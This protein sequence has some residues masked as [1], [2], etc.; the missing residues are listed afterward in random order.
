M[1][2]IPL[3]T[4]TPCDPS[5]FNGSRSALIAVNVVV[6]LLADAGMRQSAAASFAI[7]PAELFQVRIFGGRRTGRSSARGSGGL[8]LLTYMFLHGDILHLLSN[9][10]FLWVFGDNV[11]DAM[12]HLKFLV[13]YLAVRCCRRACARLDAADLARCR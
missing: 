8:T 12:G 4:T 6:Y 7:V 13:F 11:E 3:R 9:M 2:F 1:V 10:L 5:V